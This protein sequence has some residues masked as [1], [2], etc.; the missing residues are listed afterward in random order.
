MAE[1]ASPEIRSSAHLE[2]VLESTSGGCAVCGGSSPRVVWRENGYEGRACSCGTVYTWPHPALDSVD[3]TVVG[4]PDA[5]YRDTAAYKAAWL[6]GTGARGRLLEVG[7]G[8][9]DFLAAARS[10]GYEV[11]G[12]EPHP[13]RAERAAARVGA[14]VRCAR[15]EDVAWPRA[16]FDVVYHCDLL[17]HFPDP[18]GALEKMTRLLAPGGVL[19]FEVG[20]AGGLHPSWYRRIG[21]LGYPAHRWLYSRDS[22][23][24]LL[25]RAGL[26]ALHAR[27]H[28][29]GAEVLALQV[30]GTAA[31]LGRRLLPLPAAVSG[32][33][34]SLPRRGWTEARFSGVE[35]F[36]RYG[37]GR[38]FP[39]FGP[40]TLLLVAGRAS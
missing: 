32:G 40:G 12:I 2:R 11:A 28:G 10:L 30:L 16:A 15:L 22:L 38:F 35:R 9:G 3:V 5:F 4:H 1:S 24:M 39:G 29:L 33:V 27:L 18:V 36:F 23:E 17:A 6:A 26:R 21:C 14:E 19:A 7:C 34:T 31:R 37:V 20:L 25:R 8:D 13:L